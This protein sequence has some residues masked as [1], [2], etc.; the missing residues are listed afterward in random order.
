[1]SPSREMPAGEPSPTPAARGPRAPVAVQIDFDG[2]SQR[3]IS[4]PGVRERQYSSLRSGPDGIVFFME[5]PRQPG[6]GGPNPGNELL[7]YRLCDRKMTSFVNG[8]TAFDISADG[9]KL[10]YRAAAAG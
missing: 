1:E 3:V 9:R 8:V 7:R 6:G 2:L 10:L 4:I 5:S